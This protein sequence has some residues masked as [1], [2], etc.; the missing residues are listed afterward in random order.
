MGG[1]NKDAVLKYTAVMV[2]TSRCKT[3]E[4]WKWKMMASKRIKGVLKHNRTNAEADCYLAKE[5]G[6]G[7]DYCN[8]LSF[9]YH[10]LTFLTETSCCISV[11]ALWTTF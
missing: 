3:S 2:R 5:K 7:V 10:T 6:C 1:F 11:P 8:I 9:A 4:N